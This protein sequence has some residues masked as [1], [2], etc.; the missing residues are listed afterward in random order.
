MP[1][2]TL[3]RGVSNCWHAGKKDCNK[4]KTGKYLPM[5]VIEVPIGEARTDLCALVKRVESGEV[6][7]CLTSHGQP[8]AMIVPVP[9]V[10]KLWRLEKPDDP[11]RYGDLQSPVLE[12]WQ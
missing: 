7:V 9:A 4:R 6:Q 10:R 8:K 2:T 5:K 3:A 11:K 1:A 12:E